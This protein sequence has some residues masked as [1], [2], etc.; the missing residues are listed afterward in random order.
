MAQGIGE[1]ADAGN[2]DE[3][4]SE[5]VRNPNGQQMIEGASKGAGTK[6]GESTG[7]EMRESA[8]NG[9][10]DSE[11]SGVRIDVG[12]TEPVNNRPRAPPELTLPPAPRPLPVRPA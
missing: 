8:S 7:E 5:S 2:D 11:S 1:R 10:R 12:S 3:T 4:A 9:T 6:V